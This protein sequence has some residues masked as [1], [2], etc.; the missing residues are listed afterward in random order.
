MPAKSAGKPSKK[1]KDKNKLSKS[2]KN[3]DLDEDGEDCDDGEEVLHRLKQ[4]L[5]EQR[6]GSYDLIEALLKKHYKW[7]I[8]DSAVSL[9]KSEEPFERHLKEVKMG[10]IKY[11]MTSLVPI[12][13]LLT[14]AYS[15]VY[16]T[17]NANIFISG[18]I[19]SIFERAVIW[20]LGVGLLLGMGHQL[21]MARPNCRRFLAYL[22]SLLNIF[23]FMIN[24]WW[25]STQ[26]GILNIILSLAGLQFLGSFNADVRDM[27]SGHISDALTGLEGQDAK[28]QLAFLT[29]LE[30]ILYPDMLCSFLFIVNWLLWLLAAVM[31]FFV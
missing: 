4:Q 10:L 26:V 12:G 16:E 22:D 27:I 15:L 6:S 21:N 1:K 3:L 5:L 14:I 8:E 28:T 20:I 13:A 17:E 31:M 19:H 9:K 18:N 30:E 23:V 25:I 29:K 7:G 2:S 24:I 11:G